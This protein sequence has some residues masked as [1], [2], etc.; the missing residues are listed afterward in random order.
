MKLH[1]LLAALAVLAFASPTVVRA[2]DPPIET[3]IVDAMNKLFGAHPGFRAN[4]AKGIVVEG[5]FKASPEAAALSK[6]V[7][8]GGSEI[9][10]TVRFSDATGI[11]NIPDGAPPAVPHGMSIKYHLPDGS[12]TDMVLNALK[13]FPVSTG[14]D[15]RDLL[16]AL[17]A[18]PPDAAK[19][20]KFDEFVAGHPTVPA[21][22]GSTATPASFAEQEYYGIDAFVF[23]NAAGER[24]AVRY[25]MI[26]E[27]TVHLAAADAAAQAPDFL[28]AE[29][30][31]RL[32]SGPVTFRLKVQLAA[33]G[34]S[35]I[36]PAK[37]W[38]DDRKVVELGVLTIDKAVADSAEAQKALLFLPGLVTDGIEP[39]DDPLIGVRDGAY[40]ESF[41]R[42]NP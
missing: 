27:R 38:P 41:S 13:F 33:A 26:P 4:H 2:E 28:M 11:P 6:A 9:P 1:T 34:D 39:S 42:R 40:A 25:Q 36:D 37:P 29:L 20:T 7:L 16:L 30:P 15:F 3:A 18:S 24:Q 32:K 17:A 22:F 23:V 21:A 5:S 12:D 19:P 31:E 10:V 35:T 14:A 8:F